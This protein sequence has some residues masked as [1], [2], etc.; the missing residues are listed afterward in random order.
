MQSTK[1]KSRSR[2]RGEV[3]PLKMGVAIELKVSG[4]RLAMK[5]ENL[6]FCK[7]IL[8]IDFLKSFINFRGK[9]KCN[10]NNLKT[11]KFLYLKFQV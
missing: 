1:P 6:R 4:G 5:G 11:S 3:Q 10:E 8:F 2:P 7:N 9:M